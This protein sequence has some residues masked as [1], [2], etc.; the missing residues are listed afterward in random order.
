MPTSVSLANPRANS[1]R[2]SAALSLSP[3]WPAIELPTSPSGEVRVPAGPSASTLPSTERIDARSGS[4]VR[5]LSRSPSS[6]PGN[7]R[8]GVHSTASSF[9]GSTISP[10]TGPNTCV[11]TVTGMRA[12]PLPA[13][14]GRP[15]VSADV[16]AVEAAFSYAALNDFSG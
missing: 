13:P 6:S 3:I 8:L 1:S 11:S 2:R 7:T 4:S 16:V 5:R 12:R 14:R 15:T 10:F 9:T